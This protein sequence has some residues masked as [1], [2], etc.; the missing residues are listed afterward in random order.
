MGAG[1][2]AVFLFGEIPGSMALIGAAM[3]LLGVWYY[4]KIEQRT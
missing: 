2:L 4:A 3:I 1:I